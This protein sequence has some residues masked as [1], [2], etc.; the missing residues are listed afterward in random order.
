MRSP[1]NS[2]RNPKMALL[3]GKPRLLTKSP[4]R[5]PNHVG[6]PVSNTARGTVFSPR[7]PMLDSAPFEQEENRSDPIRQQLIQRGVR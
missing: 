3:D 6:H 7:N 1:R 4:A 5:G 2:K